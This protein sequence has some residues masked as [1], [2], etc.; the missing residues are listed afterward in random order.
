M[1]AIDLSAAL[2]LVRETPSFEGVRSALRDGRALTLGVGDGAKAATIAA[3]AS[4]WPGPVLVITAR[5]D[6]AEA[7]AEET[8]AWLGDPERVLLYPERDALP[9]ERLA[10]PPDVVRDRLRAITDA[11]AMASVRVI[12][13]PALAIAQRTLSRDE[14]RTSL[15][16]L[17]AGERVEIESL[18]RQLAALGYAVEPLVTEAGQVSRRGGIVDIF[19]PGA[20]LP[21]RVELHGKRD[22]EP[23]RVRSG[24]AALGAAGRGCRARSRRG[25]SASRLGDRLD[26]LDFDHLTRETRERFEEELANLRARQFVPG[27]ALLRPVPRAVDA[28]RRT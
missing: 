26:E 7:L 27:R 12:F 8:G 24:N 25:S 19:P 23:A 16:R 4:E 5:A 11:T 9:Y 20:E 22:R 14:A 6:R 28:A 2:P 18:V 10:P 3:L 17:R 1:Q 21:V 13:A 15:R